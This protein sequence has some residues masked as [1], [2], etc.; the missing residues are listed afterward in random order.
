MANHVGDWGTTEVAK[1]CVKYFAQRA[2]KAGE[3]EP[4]PN[5]RHT[6]ENSAKRNRDSPRGPKYGKAALRRAEDARASNTHLHP[7]T[8]TSFTLSTPPDQANNY[9]DPQAQHTNPESDGVTAMHVS[10]TIHSHSNAG[11]TV[12]SPKGRSA[13]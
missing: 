7:T 3:H 6:A 13:R 2:I 11:S 8:P 4:K 5:Y 10:R 9:L 12:S 1:T